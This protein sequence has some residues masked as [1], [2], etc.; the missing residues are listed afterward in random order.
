M[1]CRQGPQEPGVTQSSQGWITW[2]MALLSDPQFPVNSWK[3]E[4]SPWGAVNSLKGTGTSRAE[5]LP[6]LCWNDL[7]PIVP[8][9]GEPVPNS[10]VG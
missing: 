1:T 8:G 4:N 3:Q 2:D 7:L 5:E 9:T 6:A 10:L